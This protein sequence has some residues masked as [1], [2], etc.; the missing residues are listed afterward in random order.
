VRGKEKLIAG[1]QILYALVTVR[2]IDSLFRGKED[3]FP[4]TTSL[5]RGDCVRIIGESEVGTIVLVEHGYAIVDFSSGDK[6]KTGYLPLRGLE[7]VPEVFDERND[8]DQAG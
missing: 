6:I 1:Q 2:N 3:G 5:R 4:V 8:R 7:F